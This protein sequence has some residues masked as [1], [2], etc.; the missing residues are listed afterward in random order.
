MNAL[1]EHQEKRTSPVRVE[2]G[3][4]SKKRQN[5]YW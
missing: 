3:E 1:G 2:M 5:N 4:N